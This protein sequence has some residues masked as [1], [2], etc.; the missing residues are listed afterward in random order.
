MPNEEKRRLDNS[1]YTFAGDNASDDDNVNGIFIG[2][3]EAPEE[4]DQEQ[5]VLLSLQESYKR[6]MERKAKTIEQFVEAEAEE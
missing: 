3:A 5:D 2:E 1:S 6:H 4:Q